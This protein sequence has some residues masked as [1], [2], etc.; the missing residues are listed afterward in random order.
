MRIRSF[1]LG[2]SRCGTG[3]GRKRL[4]VT[5]SKQLGKIYLSAVDFLQQF[6]ARA[7]DALY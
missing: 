4:M 7:E 1:I 6:L 2:T 3:V 5:S